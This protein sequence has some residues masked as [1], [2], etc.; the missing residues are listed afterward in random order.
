MSFDNS[1]IPLVKFG[2]N[3]GDRDRGQL[4]SVSMNGLINNDKIL[5][6]YSSSYQ[7]DFEYPKRIKNDEQI[8]QSK[9]LRLLIE[10]DK[11]LSLKFDKAQK[12]ALEFFQSR[13]NEMKKQNYIGLI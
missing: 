7:S 4:K 2:K 3:A 13:Q 10:K 9:K 12:E 11:E 8:C 1:I 6:R 5:R